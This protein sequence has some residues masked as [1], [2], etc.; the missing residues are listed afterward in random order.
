MFYLAVFSSWYI[1]FIFSVSVFCV[2]TAARDERFDVFT[3]AN[4]M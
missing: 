2:K 4:A 3:A 1:V